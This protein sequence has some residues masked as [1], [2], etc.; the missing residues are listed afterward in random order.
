MKRTRWRFLRT[1][2][3]EEKA[4]SRLRE[5][6]AQRGAELS[7]PVPVENVVE[8]VLGLDFDWDQIEERP[9]EQ[10]LAG[11]D[12]E[13]KKIV[14]N[15]AHMAL[16][17]EKPGL[18]RSTI[19]HEAGHWDLDV[20]GC[21]SCHPRLPGFGR[22]QQVVK[23]NTRSGSMVA[24]LARAMR[25]ERAFRLYRKLTAGQDAP[26]VSSAVDRYQSA[27]L[28]PSWLVHEAGERYDITDWSDL[29]QLAGEAQVTISNLTVRLQR[30]GLIY[31]HST[32]GSPAALLELQAVRRR[33]CTSGTGH[34][35]GHNPELVR[36]RHLQSCRRRRGEPRK[37]GRHRHGD[38]L[39]R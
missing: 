27:L 17:D 16:F 12:A 13:H 30:L 29:Y 10:I 4:A 25:D 33:G 26:E 39:R 32:P 36:V 23:R 22:G 20:N 28:M 14:L 15:E 11:L 7:L 19:G 35:H 1:K 21:A 2:E 3:I 18:L 9:G 5:Y 24:V 37:R 38:E 6:E 34:D 31:I 8:Q